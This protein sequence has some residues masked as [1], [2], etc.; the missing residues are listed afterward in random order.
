MMGAIT[1]TVSEKLTEYINKEELLKLE[2]DCFLII[3]IIFPER[4]KLNWSEM[5]L[6]YVSFTMTTLETRHWES[7][8]SEWA[9]PCSQ[10]WYY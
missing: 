8:F 9:E 6:Y 7:I 4:P 10:Q 2:N 1:I 5:G 3:I